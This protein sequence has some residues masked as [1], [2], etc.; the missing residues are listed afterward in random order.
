MSILQGKIHD[1]DQRSPKQQEMLYNIEF[2]ARFGG[3]LRSE[4]FADLYTNSI[5][6]YAL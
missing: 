5:M 3:G 6:I 4:L 1:L 2:Q